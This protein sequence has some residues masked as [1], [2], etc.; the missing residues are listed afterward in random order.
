VAEVRHFQHIQ[1]ETQQGC[2]RG[3][4]HCPNK[5]IP[6]TSEQM[7]MELIERIVGQ[8]LDMDFIGSVRPYLMNE[9]FLDPRMPQIMAYIREKLPD[10][11]CLVNTNGDLLS[12]E[13]ARELGGMGVKLRVSAYG[14][15]V[16]RRFGKA[17]VPM[18]HVTDFRQAREKVPNV[19]YN[20]AGL[21]EMPGQAPVSG[22]CNYPFSQMYIRHDGRAVLCCSDYENQVVMGNANTEGLLEIFNGAR[23]REYRQ[24][25]KEGGRLPPLCSQC[26]RGDNR[27]RGTLALTDTPE[28]LWE[29][30]SLGNAAWAVGETASI[31]GAMRDYQYAALY[32]LARP[33]DGGRILEIGCYA[34]RSAAIM[35]LAAPEAKV[36][37]MSPSTKQVGQARENLAVYGVEV[38]RTKSWDYLATDKR[39]WDMV[40]VDGDHEQV[41]RD[42]P[43]YNR[44]RPG[45][46]MLFHD[47]TIPGMSRRADA[48]R[49]TLRAMAKQLGRSP[50]VVIEETSGIGMAGY[51]K[52]E[53]EGWR[54]TS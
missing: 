23:Y 49:P 15:E 5:G 32:Q 38:L 25:L 20:R 29:R 39:A 26:S 51:Y 47:Y 54:P 42:V 35:A 41:A 1:F 17:K 31:P 21:V 18:M 36:T 43:W 52:R 50:D 30:F 10:A 4:W 3:C 12:L 37:T 40:Y 24:A 53:G 11:H 45:G 19:F 2:N 22:Y 34:G 48:V 33:Y 16:A 13:L 9:P 28:G 44:I 8:L 27:L 7:P 14:D 6:R 46:L